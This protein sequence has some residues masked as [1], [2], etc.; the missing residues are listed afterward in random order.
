MDQILTDS[1][2]DSRFYVRLMGLF[3]G[4]AMLLAVIGIY[5][6]MSYFVNHRTHEIGI[7]LALG[8][9]RRDI[10]GMVTKL[11]LRLAGIG[12]VIGIVLALGLTQ[13]ITGFL[14]G[15]KPTDPVTYAAVAITLVIVAL[16]AC[17]IPARRAMRVDP[18]VALRYE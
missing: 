1:V 8:A 3:A 17:Y 2:G 11:G 18:M 7:R 5:G 13:L 6:V 12:V 14:Y 15:V 4:M 10:L 9:Q 16:F